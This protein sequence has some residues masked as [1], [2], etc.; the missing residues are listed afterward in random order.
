MNVLIVEDE[1]D[2][3]SAVVDV[4]KNLDLETKIF[5]A[6]SRDAANKMLSDEFF[7]LI[8]LDLKIPT[9]DNAANEAVSHGIAVFTNA[10]SVAPG[11]PILVLT[12]S[13]A[14]EH[15]DVI[16]KHSEKKDVWGE[17]RTI[18]MVDFLKKHRLG[19][20]PEKLMAY[21]AA[22]KSVLE[23]EVSRRECQL[24][25]AESRVIRIFSKRNDAGR[26]VV[27]KIGGGLSGAKVFRLNVLDRQG[28]TIHD[29][30]CKI[31]PIDKIYDES[32]R[33]DQYI[34][35]LNQIATPRKLIDIYCGAKD[36]GGVFYS[37]AQ[38]FVE[39]GFDLL[40]KETGALRETLIRLEELFAPWGAGESR[41]TIS[42]VRRRVL[43]DASYVAGRELLGF[44]WI[45]SFER[46][47]VQTRWCCTHG[48]LHGLNVLVSSTGTPILIDY[49]D[50]EEGPSSLDPITLELAMFFHPEGPLK[51]A[52][53]PTLDQAKMW[54]NLDI[55]LSECPCS[56]F[57]RACR[58]WSMRAAPG[59]REVAAVA[60]SYLIRQLKYDAPNVAL[61]GALIE[62]AKKMY[63]EA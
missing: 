38:G 8:I 11:T 34:S 45:E 46:Q 4:L 44:D 47:E 52:N 25:L 51:G 12:G 35:R 56:D 23:V 40:K 19:E 53:W 59:D 14:D 22:I 42:E 21:A 41:K 26:C 17:G 2:F 62:G 60:Y 57:I 33:Y 43:D 55:Y 48:D 10:K 54:G 31:G 3:A 58:G 32:H 13:S 63:D 29:A 24:T 61:I 18:P 20:L 6:R 36:T 5:Q 7:D 30:I 9:Y 50:V 37:L 1:A 39:T 49:G 15:I 16:I 28:N 27:S